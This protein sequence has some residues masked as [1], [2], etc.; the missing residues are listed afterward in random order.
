NSNFTTGPV[1]KGVAIA[2]N[3]TARRLYVTNF[4]SGTVDVFDSN[5]SPTTTPGGFADPF[6]PAGYAPFGI[7]RIGN[8]LYVT[9]AQQNM[10]KHDDVAGPGKGYLAAFDADGRLSATHTR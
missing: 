5:F 6:I 1:Y 4:R 8:V 9:Y 10:A 3:G 2:S 7:T